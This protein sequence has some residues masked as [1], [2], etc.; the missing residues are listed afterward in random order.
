VKHFETFAFLWVVKSIP[1]IGHNLTHCKYSNQ[2]P[3]IFTK[4]TEKTCLLC[5]TIFEEI[6]TFTI[7]ETTSTS[8]PIVKLALYARPLFFLFHNS[9]LVFNISDNCWTNQFALLILAM[10]CISK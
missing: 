3:V 9:F 6:Y 2:K 7:R 5:E 10:A 4:L 1:H 8:F